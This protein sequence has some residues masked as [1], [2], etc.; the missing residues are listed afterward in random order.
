MRCLRLSFSRSARGLV[1]S[2]RG[3]VPNLGRTIMADTLQSNPLGASRPPRRGIDVL[4]DP[5]SN[6]GTAF[7]EAE[8]DAHGLHGLLP[9]HVQ[10]Q[11]EQVERVLANLHRK[12]TPLE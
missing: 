3:E 10:T 4:H 12:A 5:A 9:P 7:T 8:R 1:W 11:H 6:K 2:S